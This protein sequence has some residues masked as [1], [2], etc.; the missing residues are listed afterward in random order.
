[1]SLKKKGVLMG[2]E[3]LGYER[4]RQKIVNRVRYWTFQRILSG[5]NCFSFLFFSNPY[6]SFISSNSPPTREIEAMKSLFIS[7]WVTELYQSSMWI[8]VS[9]FSVSFILEKES[10]ELGENEAR[11]PKPF[12]S[13]VG[14]SCSGKWLLGENMARGSSSSQIMSMVSAAT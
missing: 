3:A 6:F 7:V 14:V 13:W 2:A 11:S 8:S 4:E 12:S 10:W 9:L 1:M 5:L